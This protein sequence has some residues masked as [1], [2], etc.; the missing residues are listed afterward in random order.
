MIVNHGI[1]ERHETGS[2]RLSIDLSVTILQLEKN[3]LKFVGYLPRI[4][5]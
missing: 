3:P 1:K 2:T 5:L 4:E